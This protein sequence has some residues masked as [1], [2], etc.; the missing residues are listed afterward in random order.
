[1][2]ATQPMDASE[3]SRQGPTKFD[4]KKESVLAAAARIFN[5]DGVRGA[6]LADV[7]A[8]VD[9]NIKSLR[10]YF[11]RKDDLVA[12]AFLRAIDVYSNLILEAS[13]SPSAEERVRTFI[14]LYFNLAR[15]I[16]CGEVAPF[17]HFGDIRSLSEPQATP[18][19]AAFVDMFRSMRRLVAT[20]EL[21]ALGRRAL[22]ARTHLF[23]SQMLWSVVWI[24]RYEAHD[25]PRA[26]ERMADIMIN[27][28]AAAPSRET[29]CISRL[30]VHPPDANASPQYTFLRA[31]TAL[32]NDQGY[33]GASIDRIAASINMTK[34]AFYHYHDAK[35][36]VVV[37]CFERTFEM[38][39]S[40]QAL[41][42][43]IKSGLE[44]LQHSTC[45]LIYHQLTEEGPL[46]RTSALTAL[47]SDIR[48]KMTIKLD[49]ITSR[50]A[51]II[52]DGIIDGSIRPCDAWIAGQMVTA[53]IN[54]AEEL[55]RWVPEITPEDALESYLVP[56]VNGVYF[57]A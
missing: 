35:D 51:D 53:A 22:N 20:P 47:P 41:S 40:A 30:Q 38:M 32:I 27:G 31:A 29:A 8:E 3:D 16:S 34:G 10:Y 26:S 24:Q 19:F 57:C 49:R 15:A 18:V 44:R 14:R 55:P 17:L 43:N 4:L 50:F 46:L 21:E 7:A 33:R 48:V 37:A 1:M 2:T 45:L 56:S 28:L 5:R 9:L 6:T 23:I 12:A 54:A 52:S 42:E 39:R 13:Q 36:D 25:L 11:T